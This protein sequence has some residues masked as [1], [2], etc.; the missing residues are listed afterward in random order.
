MVDLIDALC[1]DAIN[2]ANHFR[3]G[4][5]GEANALLVSFIDKLAHATDRLPQIKQQ[6]L[7]LLCNNIVNAQQRN[8]P[9]YIADLLEYQI[10]ELLTI[11]PQT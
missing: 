8:D 7:E 11:E 4:F 1:E 2:T 9:I 10:T 3:L 5:V 6:Q